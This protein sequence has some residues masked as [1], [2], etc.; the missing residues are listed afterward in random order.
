[1]MQYS[2]FLAGSVL[3]A[4]ISLPSHA[5][6]IFK[7][8]E[9]GANV[10]MT[11]SGIIDTTKLVLQQG[12]SSWFGTGIEQNGNH[13][14][15]GGTAVGQVNVSFG[16]HAGTNF[17]QW[18]SANGPWASNYFS[19]IVN[20]GQKGFTTYIRANGMGPQLPGL[21][22]E[23]SDIVNGFWSPD[24][25][26][27]FAN[28]SFASLNMFSGSYAVKDAVTGESITF[29]IGELSNDVPVSSTLLLAVVGL[30]GLGL[31]RRKKL[32]V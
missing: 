24:Q 4:A 26:W 1:M 8:T 23:L 22:V 14:I 3:L 27:T 13:D 29:Q 21:G 15:M 9:S 16:F 6:I 20:S 12:V 2:K 28:H 5:G 25:M 19:A 17:S 31:S 32:K 7:F 10:V 11:S 30:A 18:A